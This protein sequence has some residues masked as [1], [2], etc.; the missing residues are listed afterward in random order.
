MYVFAA[1]AVIVGRPNS[2][3]LCAP[4][5]LLLS[6]TRQVGCMSCFVIRA[7]AVISLSLSLLDQLDLST[8]FFYSV[9]LFA[10]IKPPPL[11]F[12]RYSGRHIQT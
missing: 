7:R 4:L 6:F 1:S 9:E 8:T 10:S 11:R 12:P 2:L 5:V 3:S